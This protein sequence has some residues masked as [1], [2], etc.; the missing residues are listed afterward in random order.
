MS[1]HHQCDEVKPAC[2]GCIRFGTRCEAKALRFV[3]VSSSSSSHH[4]RQQQMAND[5]AAPTRQQQQQTDC[6]S[7]TPNYKPLE[8]LLPLLSLRT[9]R[10]LTIEVAY[11]TP[12]WQTRCIPAIHSS[13]R[14]L[15]AWDT[16]HKSVPR[17]L[18]VSLA[19]CRLSRISP[20]QN[21]QIERSTSSD[22]TCHPNEA[23]EQFSME[24]YGSLMRRIGEWEHADLRT[25]PQLALSVIILFCYLEASMGGFG[26]L[27]VH[28]QAAEGVIQSH[29]A[30]LAHYSPGLLAAWIEVRMQA[31]WRRAYFGTPEYF[32]D[33]LPPIV[34]MITGN[35]PNTRHTRRAMIL[36]LLCEA[37][38]WRTADTIA[39][40]ATNEPNL[41]SPLINS[42]LSFSNNQLSIP[43]FSQQ[44]DAWHQSLTPEELPLSPGPSDPPT[45]SGT[46][47]LHIQPLLFQSHP[48]AMNFAYYIMAEILVCGIEPRQ[49]TESHQEITDCSVADECAAW[50]KLLLQIAAG[51]DWEHCLS[52]NTY[53]IGIANL[54]LASAIYS[55]SFAVSHWIELWLVGH[56]A[57]DCLEEGNFPLF[58]ILEAIQLINKERMAGQDVLGLFQ[59]VNDA[60]GGGKRGAYRS[61]KID[62]VLVY[63]RC[64][65]TG[66]FSIYR[67]SL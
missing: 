21:R 22:I 46:S 23:D 8:N 27:N 3:T 31:W 15:N 18:M 55:R 26:A 30:H 16:R 57:P 42:S 24:L 53:T 48:F 9:P 52:C 56:L 38:R 2:G 12:V 34:S 47:E 39:A 44:L 64:I 51:L 17:A 60:G 11:Y 37:H 35:I 67:R 29:F 20:T 40:F 62:S 61:Q 28:S 63:A 49:V 66:E 4:Q 65:A 5:G 33:P 6:N 41:S 32:H 10:D 50:G 58:Q 14:H 54:L 36:S 59:A 13:F 7:T 1:D 25:H 43:S 19:A 45:L